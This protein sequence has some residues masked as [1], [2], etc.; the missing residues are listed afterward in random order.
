MEPVADHH[1]VRREGGTDALTGIEA[2]AFVDGLMTFNADSQA[3]QLMRLYSAAFDRAPDA[4]G[5][6]GSNRTVDLG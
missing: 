6:H 5:F 2:A 1:A 4:T 3:A